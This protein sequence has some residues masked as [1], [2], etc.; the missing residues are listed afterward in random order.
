MFSPVAISNSYMVTCAQKT[1][2]F[3]ANRQ[4]NQEIES[5]G[6]KT[7]ATSHTL[8][9]R[10]RDETVDKTVSTCN[11]VSQEGLHDRLGNT[12][13]LKANGICQMTYS[14][15]HKVTCSPKEI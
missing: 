15:K 4:C 6:V 3:S 8:D 7:P 13:L 2:K 10:N 11:D 14:Y 1:Q 5:F 12:N 9:F